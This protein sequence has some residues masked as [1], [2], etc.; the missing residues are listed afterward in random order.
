MGQ[1]KLQLSQQQAELTAGCAEG[2]QAEL[3]LYAVCL[4]KVDGPSFAPINGQLN[5]LFQMAIVLA[6]NNGL[7]PDEVFMG[8]RGLVRAYNARPGGVNRLIN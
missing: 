7:D 6:A 8:A 5:V 3:D 1:L 4:P 2:I